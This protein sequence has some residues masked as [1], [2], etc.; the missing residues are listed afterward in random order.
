MQLVANP[1]YPFV[2]LIKKCVFVFVDKHIDQNVDEAN[3][4]LSG[5]LEKELKDQIKTIRECIEELKLSIL[6][7]TNLVSYLIQRSGLYA[8]LQKQKHIF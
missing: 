6:Q 4:L 2:N 7:K 3:K 8:Y 1:F 5:Q